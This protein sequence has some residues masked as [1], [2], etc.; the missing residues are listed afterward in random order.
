MNRLNDLFLSS[1]PKIRLWS[2]SGSYK[3]MLLRLT[4]SKNPPAFVNYLDMSFDIKNTIPIITCICPVLK[5]TH[6]LRDHLSF[7]LINTEASITLTDDQFVQLFRLEYAYTNG[8]TIYSDNS[9]YLADLIMCYA[10]ILPIMECS[11]FSPITCNYTD[12]SFGYFNWELTGLQSDAIDIKSKY[13]LKDHLKLTELTYNEK[14]ILTQYQVDCISEL[15][16][17]VANLQHIF[18]M[19][20]VRLVDLCIIKQY[21]QHL[22]VCAHPPMFTNYS[23]TS[24][25][26]FTYSPLDIRESI[27][28][29]SSYNLAKHLEMVNLKGT[30]NIRL[31]EDQIITLREL[32][33]NLQKPTLVIEKC[34]LK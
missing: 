18:F 2:L 29:K 32:V 4:C 33:E 11:A 23:D 14:L 6:S 30:E 7:K 3:N 25:G 24:F 27:D 9:V 10:D 17:A 22:P 20:R 34:Y 19:D 26:Y 13:S 31:T 1:Y 12:N 16:T 8:V 15:N 21:I 28:V 5:T